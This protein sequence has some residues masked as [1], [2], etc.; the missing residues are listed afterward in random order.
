MSKKIIDL[1]CTSA[2]MASGK[3]ITPGKIVKG[4]PAADAKS[5]IRRGK[6]KPLN[7]DVIEEGETDEAPA[8]EELTVDELKATA[9]EYGIEN[10]AKMKKAELIAAIQAAEAE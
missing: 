5:L 2:F 10:A 6:A 3:M 4:V 1:K 7:G 8:L 9:E